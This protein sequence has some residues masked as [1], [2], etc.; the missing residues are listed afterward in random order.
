MKAID[1]VGRAWASLVLL[2]ACAAYAQAP[3]ALPKAL[4]W[5]PQGALA[6]LRIEQPAELLDAASRWGLLEALSSNPDLSNLERLLGP[7]GGKSLVSGLTA[8][9]LTVAAYPGDRTVIVADARDA[10]SL[11]PIHKLAQT[12]V[13]LQKNSPKAGDRVFYRE[14]PGGA[15]WTFDGKQFFA[16]MGGRLAMSS[17]ADVLKALF[18]PRPADFQPLS[19]WTVLAEA[20]KRLEGGAGW[21]FLNLALLNQDPNFRKSLA[22]D[23]SALDVIVAGFLRQS[24]QNAPWAGLAL[25]IEG[26]EFQIRGFSDGRLP[27][28]MAFTTPA[29]GQGLLPKLSVPREL[30]S[31]SLWR[32][33][34][35]F[36]SAR[37]VIFPERSSAGILFENFM[38][39]FFSGRDLKNEVF[40]RFHPAVRLVVAEQRYDPAIGVPEEPYPAVALVFRVDRPDEFGEIF[41]EA[42]Q[43]AIGIT[44]FTRGQQA[45][46][47]IILD[48]ATHAGVT[49][50][51][52]YFSVRGEKDRGKL[53][54]RFNVRPSLAR[55]G[56]YFIL[57][58]TDQLARDLIDAV[59]REDG[60][61][62]PPASAAHTLIEI[63]SGAQIAALLEA[64]RASYL[65]QNVLSS[66]KKP[67]AAAK[68]FDNNLALLRRIAGATLAFTSADGQTA[69]L[70]VR[71]K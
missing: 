58:S 16:S 56:P 7:L 62:P 46:P 23:G 11:E 40:A 10:S 31:A 55:T 38:E 25:R 22:G 2:L 50:T 42:W 21:L 12:L 54:A 45:Q 47:G 30:A 8:G 63:G 60:R 36:Y 15:S 67:E 5:L 18:Q 4:E 70:T 53:P 17:R 35:L 27:R 20:R 33:L 32:D 26:G 65:R 64:N 37:D 49:F 34:A 19:S 43:K 24:L 39:I 3:P 59:R 1:V 66:G 57:S 61:T 13:A 69:E 51:Y 6:V 71:I 48:K 41:E 68:E 29:P 9:G 14:H 52:G 28:A 44:N